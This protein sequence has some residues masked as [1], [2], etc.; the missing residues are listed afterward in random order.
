MDN[1]QLKQ[2]NNVYKNT[3]ESLEKDKADLEHENE[4]FEI[5]VNMLKDSEKQSANRL[6]ELTIESND[7]FVTHQGQVN[8]LKT[9]AEHFEKRCIHLEREN[10][11]LQISNRTLSYVHN[12][13]LLKRILFL[14]IPKTT[15][16][17]L[18]D[19]QRK[20]TKQRTTKK[21]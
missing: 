13:N 1:L 5:Q 19:E 7:N 11:G 17:R 4:L 16:W 15:L 12:M 8:K 10:K 21:A 2:L 3:I 6:R 18:V 20:S 14:F 9:I